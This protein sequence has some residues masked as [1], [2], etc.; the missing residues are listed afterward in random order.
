MNIKLQFEVE[1]RLGDPQISIIIDDNMPVYTGVC[2]DFY[3]LNVAVIPGS[4]DLRIIHYGKT[5]EDHAYDSHG[6]L[7][8]DKH[9]KIKSILFDDVE[10]KDELWDGE[11]YPVYNTDYL[12][13][14]AK[15]N[16]SVPYSLKPNLYLGHNGTWTLKFDFPSLDW[17]IKVR[18][19]KIIKVS[20]PDF[21]TREQDLN[22]AKQFFETAPDLPWDKDFVRK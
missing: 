16:I 11:F 6:E 2:K 15:N 7:T 22:I 10:L 14:C 19:N 20:D 12:D 17:L 18:N 13:D 9:V 3:E 1:R 4:H 21:L 8:I 5:V